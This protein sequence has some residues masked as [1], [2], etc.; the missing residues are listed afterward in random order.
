MQELGSEDSLSQPPENSE[1]ELSPDLLDVS[2]H[3][4]DSSEEGSDED[5]FTTPAVTSRRIRRVVRQSQSDSDNEVQIPSR[6]LEQ[7]A[8]D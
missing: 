7:S 6:D 3:G 8:S 5:V 2:H 4:G 1:D